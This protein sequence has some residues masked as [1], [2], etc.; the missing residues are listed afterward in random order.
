MKQML[1]GV[2]VTGGESC[3]MKQSQNDM[4]YAVVYMVP[5]GQDCTGAGQ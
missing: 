3:P 4:A 5:T 2:R 1:G